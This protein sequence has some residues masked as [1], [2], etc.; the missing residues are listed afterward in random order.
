MDHVE[1]TGWPRFCRR[2]SPT[3][4]VTIKCRITWHKLKGDSTW[5]IEYHFF[6]HLWLSSL[7][8]QLPIETVDE[9]ELSKQV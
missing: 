3:F 7:S 2:L 6:C 5:S 4:P 9:G 1:S 8:N